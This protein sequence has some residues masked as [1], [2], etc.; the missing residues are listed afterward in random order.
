MNRAAAY[1]FGREVPTAVGPTVARRGHVL[2]PGRTAR[3]NIEPGVGFRSTFVRRSVTAGGMLARWAGM[4]ASAPL[5]IGCSGPGSAGA[6]APSAVAATPVTTVVQP[7][8]IVAPSLRVSSSLPDRAAASGSTTSAMPPWAHRARVAPMGTLSGSDGFFDLS[9]SEPIQ[10]KSGNPRETFEGIDCEKDADIDGVLNCSPDDVAAYW[11][12]CEPTDGEWSCLPFD[13]PSSFAAAGM[14]PLL[15]SADDSPAFVCE[16]AGQPEP[17][18]CW[19]LT[20]RSWSNYVQRQAPSWYVSSRDANS[21]IL[22]PT[23]S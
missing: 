8:T 13:V 16:S 15:A 20:G 21:L 11:W 7:A 18:R 10:T 14:T 6:S 3:S 19:S 2:A 4:L 1:P 17:R 12:A 23:G 22:Y 5:A 9:L